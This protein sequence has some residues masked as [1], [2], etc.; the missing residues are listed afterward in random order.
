MLSCAQYDRKCLEPELVD[1]VVHEQCLNQVAAPVHLQLRTVFG[2]ELLDLFHDVAV[3][4]D[5]RLPVQA[6]WTVG[7]DIFRSTVDRM[8]GFIVLLRPERGKDPVG[9][10]A[11][12]E[13]KT[14]PHLPAHDLADRVVEVPADHSPKLET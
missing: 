8:S 11:Q 6:D 14:M 7:D 4:Q 3:E 12:Q 9:P 1:Q 5:R 10:P 13:I 2:L